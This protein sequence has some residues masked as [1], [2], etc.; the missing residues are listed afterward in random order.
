M[1][2]DRRRWNVYD[3]YTKTW[4]HFRSGNV[5]LESSI[6]ELI[7][8]Q[9]QRRGLWEISKKVTILLPKI[10]C[11]Q[12]TVA[13]RAAITAAAAA[14]LQLAYSWMHA[15]AQCC[16]AHGPDSP[17]RRGPF[18]IYYGQTCCNRHSTQYCNRSAWVRRFGQHSKDTAKLLT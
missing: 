18:S 6:R 12:Q 14:D 16:T 15:T 9:H 10:K 11:K 5:S 3:S 2:L 17:P 1:P 8:F 13:A 7:G 4:Q